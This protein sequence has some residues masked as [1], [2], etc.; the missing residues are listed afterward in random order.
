MRDKKMNK[1]NSEISEHI[2]QCCEKEGDE[3][4]PEIVLE[5]LLE[6]EEISRT[7][8]SKHRWWNVFQYVVKLEGML[9]GY[10]YAEA[11]RDESVLDLGYE[12]DW[13][14]VRKMRP[15]EKTITT[16]VTCK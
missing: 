14:S 11:N 4:E 9:I 16:Y 12:F 1:I 7:E 3:F 5:Y 10:Q 13:S 15:V 2:K 8:L 6:A